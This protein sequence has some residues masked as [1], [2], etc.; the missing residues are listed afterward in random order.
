M[1]IDEADDA[2][3]GAP[4]GTWELFGVLLDRKI[5]FFGSKCS[6]LIYG[7]V[8]NHYDESAIDTG[9]NTARVLTDQ[10]TPK[11]LD[12]CVCIVQLEV[13]SLPKPCQKACEWEI[14]TEYLLTWT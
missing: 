10:R 7:Q 9:N 12:Q 4:V 5:Y 2:N 13:L 1:G 3:E 8:E 11:F 14:D 6:H